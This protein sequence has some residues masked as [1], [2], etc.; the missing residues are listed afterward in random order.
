MDGTIP[1]VSRLLPAFYRLFIILVGFSALWLTAC[2][3]QP[4][5]VDPAFARYIESFTSGTISRQ[6]PI[7]IRLSSQITTLHEAGSPLP[8]SLFRFKP[9]VTGEARRIDARTIAFHPAENLKPGR[10]YTVVFD[11]SAVADV[12]R[13]LSEF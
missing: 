9:G 7:Q 4:S 13:E 8:S 2:Q 6:S 12:P 3:Q 5:K 1:A 10:M 11:L